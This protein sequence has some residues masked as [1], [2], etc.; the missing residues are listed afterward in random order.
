MGVAMLEKNMYVRCPVDQEDHNNPREFLMGQVISVDEISEIVT[1]K[2]HD[3]FGFNRYYDTIPDGNRDFSL[4]KID[5]CKLLRGSIVYYNKSQYEVIL[6]YKEKEDHWYSY[7]LRNIE[8]RSIKRVREDQLTAP[9]S[10]GK[11]SPINQIKKYEFQNPSWYFGR[12]VVNR[13]M[14]ILKNSFYGFKEITGCKIFLMPHQIHTIIRCIQEEKCRF[15]IADEV[16][17]GKT[18][19]ACSILKVYMH[20]VSNS[21]LLIAVPDTLYEQW[22]V[23]LFVK[24]EI[25]IGRNEN[26]NTLELVPFSKL[27]KI[28]TEQE[29]DFVIVDETHRLLLDDALYSLVHGL[30]K[31]AENILLLSATPVQQQRV[32]YLRLLRLIAPERYDGM[33]FEEFDVLLKKQNNLNKKAY[34]VLDDLEDYELEINDK[35]KSLEATSG[36][37]EDQDLLDLFEEIVDQLQD[38]AD[39]VNNNIYEEL[40]E[41]I[42]FKS[43]DL[44]VS[45]LK[46]AISYICENYQIEKNIIRTRRRGIGVDL[47][48]RNYRS[49]VYSMDSE[50]NNLESKAYIALSDW[51]EDTQFDEHTFGQDIIP[52]I[53]SFFSSPWSFSK[54]LKD[55]KLKGIG[56]SEDLEYFSLRWSEDEEITMQKLEEVLSDP[57]NISNRVLNVIDYIDQEIID[58]K[59]VVFTSFDETFKKYREY[60]SNYFG[61]NNCSFFNK[62]M[63]KEELELNVYRFQSDKNCNIMLCDESGGEGRNF[64]CAD[65]ILHIDLPWDASAIEQRIGR[66]DRIGRDP[67]KDVTSIVVYSSDTIEEQLF[68]F[69]NE[70]LNIFKES[71]SGL[72][73]VMKEIN[74]RIVGSVS[75]NFKYGLEESIDNMIDIAREMEKSINEERVF[76]IAASRY[77]PLNNEIDRLINYYQENENLLFSNS[78]MSWA[79]LAGLNPI[80]GV[81]FNQNIVRFDEKSFSIRSAERAL[82]IPPNWDTY[83]NRDRAIHIKKI[84]KLYEELNEGTLR[85]EEIGNHIEGTFDRET[86]IKNDLLHFFSPGDDI[87]DC[88]VE[89]ALNSYKGQSSAFVC[90][91]DID[92]KGFVFTWSIEPNEKLLLDNDLDISALSQLRSLLSIDQVMTAIPLEGYG[93][94]SEDEVLNVL[95]KKISVGYTSELKN[96]VHLGRRSKK[97]DF[98]GVC[99]EFNKSN[100]EWFKEY[101]SSETWESMVNESLNEAKKIALKKFNERS[102]IE[103]ARSE[104][105]NSLI[106]KQVADMFYGRKSNEIRAMERLGELLIKSLERHKI[107]LE[108]VA[109]IWMVKS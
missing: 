29:Y 61:I 47:A 19:E 100:I 3:P 4:N 79:K 105:Q 60:F 9:F 26:G 14:N 6:D 42:D 41:E 104:I 66:L 83:I 55:L 101:Y 28:N 75:K 64:Q 109:Y 107:K 24:Y 52:L 99:S 36:L 18:I 58:E 70:G 43:D 90:K 2:F 85:R 38:I 17:L 89:N 13:T 80:R 21:R 77:K 91:S 102:H 95:N 1:V 62:G 12:Q 31:K 57:D 93:G 69:W 56:L 71:L 72:E 51:L 103:K 88:I 44:G 23:E 48:K 108:S 82:L 63:T 49:L 96:L 45:R 46:L 10:S 20:K 7:Y 67:D 22:K 76:D 73:I 8:D 40:L 92:W 74:D 39:V 97:R 81:G 25:V 5:R 106:T 53:S 37:Q 27:D 11:I 32:E 87:F 86:S 65:Y 84:K 98:L 68:R 54:S 15:M 30:S 35:E 34:M 78:M 33:S 50:R 59:V 16:G 94:V